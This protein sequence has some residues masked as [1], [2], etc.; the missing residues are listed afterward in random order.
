VASTVPVMRF[1]LSGDRQDDYTLRSAIVF[2][3][4]NPFSTAIYV[5][6]DAL[7]ASRVP[8]NKLRD[9]HDAEA[10]SLESPFPLQPYLQP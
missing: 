8:Q 6:G 7:I 9:Q 10:V 4:I 5:T 2:V 1:T 3:A